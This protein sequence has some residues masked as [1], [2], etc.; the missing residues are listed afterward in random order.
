MNTV[1][2]GFWGAFFGSVALMLAGSLMAYVR[3]LHRVALRAGSTAALS[4][5]FV[6]SYVGWL[7]IDDID[8]EQRVLAHIAAVCS[9]LLGLMLLELMGRE[10]VAR[11]RLPAAGRDQHTF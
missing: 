6:I 5:L 9:A 2:V 11:W 3:S 4:A 1:A 8:I 7:P 10:A